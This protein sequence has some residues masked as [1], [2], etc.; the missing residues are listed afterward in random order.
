[1]T[2]SNVTRALRAAL[3]VFSGAL[4]LGLAACANTYGPPVPGEPLTYG[5]QRYIENEKA[6]A[7][8]DARRSD[9]SNQGGGLR[10]F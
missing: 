9:R 3:L 10:G 7:D 6:Q 2:N 8:H 1:M 4:L 5:Q